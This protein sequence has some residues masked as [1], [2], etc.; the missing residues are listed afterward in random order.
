MSYNRPHWDQLA[1]REAKIKDGFLALD[2]NENLDTLYKDQIMDILMN[3]IDLSTATQYVDYYSY[4]QQL[5]DWLGISTDNML[6]TAGCDQ[7]MDIAYSLH[8][9][10]NV[11]RIQPTYSGAVQKVYGKELVDLT[12][13]ETPAEIQEALRGYQDVDMCYICSPNNPSG[14]VYTVDFLN[15]LMEEFAETIFFID[16][17]YT[18]FGGDNY[19]QLLDNDNCLIGKSFSKGWGLAGMR[20]G[21]LLGSKALI[22]EATSIR[23]I[24]PVSSITL[25]LVSYLII[26][27]H[28]VEKTVRRNL[29]GIKYIYKYFDDCVIHSEPNIN[30]IIFDARPEL[31]VHL[32]N[33][34]VLYPTMPEF[35]NTAIKLTTL[36]IDQF[37]SL[38]CSDISK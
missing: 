33:K 20:M 27:I 19:L 34:K 28:I 11:V 31:I 22:Q 4:Y 3:K 5:S 30:H 8:S 23:P 17:T 1:L 12:C 25:A 37:E 15:E 38:I 21:L 36:P 16:N 35:S 9:I 6:I 32:H 24:M 18:E 13:G 29:D 26:N 7:A 14:R 10:R 2:R